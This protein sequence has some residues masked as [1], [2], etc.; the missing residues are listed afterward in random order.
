MP[1]IRLD[2]QGPLLIVTLDRPRA[3]ALN[4]SMVDELHGA[5]DQ[6]QDPS[7]RGVVFASSSHK[8]FCAG[9]DVAEV[10][11]YDRPAMTQFFSR[12]AD[13]FERV[14]RLPKPVAAAMSGH[15]YAAGA[16]LA[17]ACDVRVMADGAGFALNEIN[18][19]LV[20]PTRMIRAMAQNGGR[21][22][23]SLLLCGDA[24][25]ASRA[26]AEGLITEV[27]P[28]ID[29]LPVTLTRARHLAEKPPLAFAG[30]KESL[31][32]VGLPRS[33]A[34]EEGELKRVVDVW[35]SDEAKARRQALIE[36]LA[37]KS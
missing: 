10:F 29:V 34:D 13:L 21:I 25:A 19:G 24:V 35:F 1:D 37:K 11:A 18:L 22:V 31:D 14:R 36:T 17:L 28:A 2:R 27:A 4:A 30:H 9:F 6:A 33:E 5:V 32:T 23:R 12:F 15:A 8:V 20:L 16:I 26:E 7:V 3:N